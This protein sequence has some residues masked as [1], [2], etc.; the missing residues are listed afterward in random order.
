MTASL[1]ERVRMADRVLQW[2]PVARMLLTALVTTVCLTGSGM[3]FYFRMEHRVD[4]NSAGLVDVKATQGEVRDDIDAV[5]R[6][7]GQIQTDQRVLT[8]RFEDKLTSDEKFQQRTDRA[9]ERIQRL[10]DRQNY[11][12]GR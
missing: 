7:V 11:N 5:R 1:N 6:S 8:Q 4:N 12:D 10:L 3:A 9:L 2:H